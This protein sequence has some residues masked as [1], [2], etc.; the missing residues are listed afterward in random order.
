MN[1]APGAGSLDQL[2]SSPARYHFAM[3]APTLE[4]KVLQ[5]EVHAIQW[6]VCSKW[7]I[8][9][10]PECGVLLWSV[11]VIVVVI[12]SVYCIHLQ[13]HYIC[14]LGVMGGWVGGWMN[15][16]EW[17]GEWVSGWVDEW[18]W[19][20]KWVRKDEWWVGWRIVYIVCVCRGMGGA[21]KYDLMGRWVRAKMGGV[22]G[23]GIGRYKNG[24]M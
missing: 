15:G 23:V 4:Y 10:H 9:P 17:V 14:L 24:W 13:H 19:M 11:A 12:V 8:T 2:T 20:D 5:Q 22:V 6:L 21:W 7:N 1:H 18:R 3:D 16:D